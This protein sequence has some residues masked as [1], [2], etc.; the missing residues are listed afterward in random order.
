M[1]RE[2]IIT[3]AAGLIGSAVTRYL[4]RNDWTVHAVDIKQYDMTNT[5]HVAEMCELY[6]LVPNLINCFAFNDHVKQSSD[7]STILDLD[8]VTFANVMNVNVTALFDVCRSYAR[9]RSSI[10]QGGNII[11]FGA[12][13][14]IVSAR[15][16]MYEG[17]HKN[18]A[19]SISKAAVIHMTKILS[20]HFL[21]LNKKFRVNCISPGGVIAD[22]G[23][24]FQ[25]LY[26][27]HTPAGRMLC[28]E[29]LFPVVDMLLDPRN[30]Y[31]Q[32]ANIVVDGG[33][34][35]Q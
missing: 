5:H 14:G 2:V 18:A 13:T 32:G 30:T 11:N 34:T 25:S 1:Q 8:P 23:E 21:S 10:D 33:W 24:E 19:Y 9:V 27:S 28:V 22:Q 35:I 7:R 15:T 16:D 29:E 26:G 6:K 3:G 4:H 12:S 20:T 17:N 31:M